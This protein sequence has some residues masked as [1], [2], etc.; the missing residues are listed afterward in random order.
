MIEL[1]AIPI[2][3]AALLQRAQSPEAGAVVMFLGVS[4]RITAGRE[5]VQLT[6]DAYEEMA[7]KELERLETEARQRWPVVECS[8]VHRQG[9]VPL[10]EASVAVAVASAH[11][12]EAFEAGQW[13]I[14]TL[15]QRVPIWKQ[16]H[17]ADG[18]TQWVHP[19]EEGRNKGVG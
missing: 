1:T 2:D 18:T 16:E 3:S 12:R 11:R 10:G 14:D 15:K 5:T 19:I 4:R 17:W 6:Y 7:A 8:I 13:L 9:L